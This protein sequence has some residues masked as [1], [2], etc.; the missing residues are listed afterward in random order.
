MKNSFVFNKTN[1]LQTH[2]TA[3]GTRMAPSYANLFMG[4]LEREFLQ[5]QDKIPREWWRHIDDIFAIWAHGEPSLRVFI[6][7]LNRHHPTIKFTASWSANEVTFLDTRVFL[8]DGLIGT[9]LHVKPTDT[10]QYLRMDS[11][12]PHHC[13][14]SIRIVKRSASD[15]FVRRKAN[16]RS[17]PANLKNI[18]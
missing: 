16:Y 12:H 6:E 7:N 17:G 13:K 5:T 18:Y 11:C 8:R 4:K 3:M 15:E 2:G 10:H 14:T 9:D 1:Y